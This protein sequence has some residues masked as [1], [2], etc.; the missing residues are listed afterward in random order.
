VNDLGIF[1]LGGLHA[2][3]LLFIFRYYSRRSIPTP[4]PTRFERRAQ[5]ERSEAGAIIEDRPLPK[6]PV[7][8]TTRIQERNEAGTITE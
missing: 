3:V 4:S 7:N 6:E 1:V 2:V 5:S 8:K